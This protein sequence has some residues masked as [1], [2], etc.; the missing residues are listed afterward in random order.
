VLAAAVEALGV[1]RHVVQID[2]A[3]RQ[4]ERLL[5]GRQYR[6]HDFGDELGIRLL[7]HVVDRAGGT[8]NIVCGYALAL[9]RKLVAAVRSADA[10]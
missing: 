4:P 1:A 5:G 7:H 6:Q 9:A 2:L 8:Q 3:E 10:L